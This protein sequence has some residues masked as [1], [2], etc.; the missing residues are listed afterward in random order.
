MNSIIEVVVTDRFHCISSVSA[1][2]TALVIASPTPSCV[3]NSD[4]ID[5]GNYDPDGDGGVE[6]F[7]IQCD[8]DHLVVHH[9]NEDRTQV[10]GFG[11]SVS[12]YLVR[13]ICRWLKKRPARSSDRVGVILFSSEIA[14]TKF[15]EGA[16]K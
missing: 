6:S 1:F 8:G 14:G 3:D 11:P 13:V 4:L 7:P 16:T 15:P 2:Y 12:L 10:D 5:S 9:N